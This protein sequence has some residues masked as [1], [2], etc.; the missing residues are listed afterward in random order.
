[1]GFNVN[2][3]VLGFMLKVFRFSGF[4]F[5]VFWVQGLGST[6]RPCGGSGSFDVLGALGS[7]PLLFA[8]ALG[9]PPLRFARRCGGS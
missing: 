5:W 4:E 8:G 6:I 3:K 9:S 7:P 1:L 2:F